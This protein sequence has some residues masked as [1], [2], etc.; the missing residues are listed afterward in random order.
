MDK[1]CSFGGSLIR[2][3]F[4]LITYYSKKEDF[5]KHF[6][7][8]LFL[9]VFSFSNNL[10]SAPVDVQRAKEIAVAFQ[11]LSHPT[12]RAGSDELELVW[13]DVSTLRSEQASSLFVFNN[14]TRQGFIIIA[15]DDAAYPVL[16][17]SDTNTFQA[18]GMPENLAGWLD[19]Y[20]REIQYLRDNDIR[21]DEDVSE[22][23]RRL[24]TKQAALR[25]SSEVMIETALWNQ[26]AP[27]NKFC[28]KVGNSSTVTGC[29][30]TALAIV[31]KHNR[32]PDKS[33]G[34]VLYQTATEKISIYE[35]LNTTYEW[36]QM[37]M[38]Y[39]STGVTGQQEDAVATL[40]YHCG[41]V[42][43]MD[44]GISSSG[45]YNSTAIRNMVTHMKYD[46]S[47]KMLMRDWYS[48]EEWD[49]MV[50]SELDKNRP[51]LY[52][53]VTK[54]NQ[55][56]LF[57]CDGYTSDDFFHINW[58]W[59]G[60][61]NGYFVLSS[62]NPSSPGIGGAP[63]G[64]VEDQ[65]IVVD[66]IP[67]EG[68]P[69]HDILA[70]FYLPE[71]PPGLTAYSEGGYEPNKTFRAQAGYVGNQS[72]RL[73]NGE[74]AMT[75]CDVNG[76]I[77]EF[78]SP[79]AQIED[80]AIQYGRIHS[81]D[82]VIVGDIAPGDRLRLYYKS[83]DSEEWRWVLGGAG[84]VAEVIIKDPDAAIP[85]ISN[86]PEVSVRII[87]DKLHISSSHA[88]QQVR[89]HDASGRQ[90]E[91]IRTQANDRIEIPISQRS[92]GVYFVQVISREGTTI[93]KI[94]K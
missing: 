28:P 70:Y 53:G 62:L 82:C 50:R 65:M 72:I 86:L 58:G 15:G 17:Y 85:V 54:M 66:F 73:F 74:V 34:L 63:G 57:V 94:V 75:L 22:Q 2:F 33:Q 64:Y 16:G 67:D 47:V 44:Y 60:V 80:L 5:M 84:T 78:V 23:W 69:Y 3:D 90:I 25:S 45:A 27:Y 6:Y 9:V 46:K 61:S 21:A 24:E 31:A 79:P 49:K 11:K 36:D 13:T 8:F 4:L 35:Y 91:N 68:N 71:G 38:E 88:I 48:S 1:V 81:F 55:G 51:V 92:P 26:T 18:E 41:I 29:V 30:A 19:K 77:K 39:P 32:W 10:Y 93:R 37:L 7:L 14:I 52:S 87:Q 59:S 20:V 40:I 76:Q 83:S 43:N 89:I 42:S 12:L 56:H